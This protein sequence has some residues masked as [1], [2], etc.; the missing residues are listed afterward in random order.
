MK[1]ILILTIGLVSFAC[2]ATPSSAAW[3]WP[4]PGYSTTGISASDNSHYRGLVA[5]IRDWRKGRATC[6]DQ[7]TALPIGGQ[8]NAGPAQPT[9]PPAAPGQ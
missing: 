6:C 2:T 5:L 7:A 8:G 9:P 1:F 3:G 4:P